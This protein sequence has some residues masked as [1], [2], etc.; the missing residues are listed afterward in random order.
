L[1][2]PRVEKGWYALRQDQ[3]LRRPCAPRSIRPSRR[4]GASFFW[5]KATAKRLMN[6][7]LEAA[8]EFVEFVGGVEVGFEFAGGEFI[9]EVVEAASEEIE[10]GGED[11]AIGENDI[12]PDGVGAASEAEGISETGAGEGD[13]EAV[14]V[15]MVVEESAEGN[16][17]EL[18][19]M[20]G[21]PDGVVVL[22]GTEPEG[23]GADFLEEFEE[24]GDAR[25]G[26]L[27]GLLGRDGIKSGRGKPRPYGGRDEGVGGVAEEVGGGVGDAGELA[28][29][30]GVAAEEER[31]AFGGEKFGGGLGDAKFGAAGVGD[32]G[33]SGSVARDFGEKVESGADG[34][35]DVDEVRVA[36]GPGEVAGEGFVD[37]VAG[38]GFAEDIGAVPAG[39]AE[40]G[41][42]F[43]QGEREG[44]AD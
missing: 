39:D 40:V 1:V 44:A 2:W 17:G 42:V 20:G 12:A 30:H 5:E 8:E 18:G 13:G 24:G 29:C 37:G 6:V 35:R 21:Q 27:P 32:E 15:E 14:F 36:E 22:L 43:T 41:G 9:A 7:P 28:A 10:S 23:A 19:K 34:K 25:V 26:V 38:A 16:G 4:R 11:F 33:V 3:P 31:A